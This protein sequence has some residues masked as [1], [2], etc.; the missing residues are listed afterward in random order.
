MGF[1]LKLPQ[2]S[3]GKA[4]RVVLPTVAVLLA[5][6]L[7][8]LFALHKLPAIKKKAAAPSVI[9]VAAAAASAPLLSD[10][11]DPFDGAAIDAAPF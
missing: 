1:K 10:A 11:V 8:I 7:V 2:V 6:V 4:L 5:I 3:P 9:H